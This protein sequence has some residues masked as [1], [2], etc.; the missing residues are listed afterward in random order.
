LTHPNTIQIYDYGY[1][2]DG[3]FY[4]AMEYLRGLNLMELVERFGPQPEGR[5]VH[6]LSQ[7]CGA[8]HEAHQH[9]LVHRDIKPANVFLCNRGE[10]ADSV[11]VLDFGLVH[12]YRLAPDLS[13]PTAEETPV[14]GTPHFMSPESIRSAGSA[15]PRSDIYALGAL[16]YY[17]ITGHLVFEDVSLAEVLRRHEEDKPMQPRQRTVNAI[18]LELEQTLLRCL[19][20]NPRRRPQSA[21]ELQTLLLASPRAA[22]WDPRARHEWW[23][24]FE[25]QPTPAAAPAGGTTLGNLAATIR[26][27]VAPRRL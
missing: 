9:G 2:P 27:D 11:K 19:E 12:E 15:D 21:I 23:A 25:A 8:L 4:Y 5:V 16:G 13:H 26:I 3:L 22:E 10:M 17:L 6:I 14:V 1:T 7:V 24:G 20:K 18:T